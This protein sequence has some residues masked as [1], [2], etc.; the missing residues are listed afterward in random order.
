MYAQLIQIWNP[1]SS[2]TDI[3]HNEGESGC[4]Q[5]TI[6][7]YRR[8]WK[9]C[10][11]QKIAI[12][13]FEAHAQT[14][15]AQWFSHFDKCVT[16]CVC[17]IIPWDRTSWSVDLFS[18]DKDEGGFE[19]TRASPD[20]AEYPSLFLFEVQYFSKKWLRN[21]NWTATSFKCNQIIYQRMQRK[22]SWFEWLML[23]ISTLLYC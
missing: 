14:F 17:F 6:S 1:S 9:H 23:S 8:S 10:M 7:E 21:N 22:K 11:T 12:A 15:L 5:V 4:K 2:Q 13:S 18:S 19:N 3:Q 20:F 16:H